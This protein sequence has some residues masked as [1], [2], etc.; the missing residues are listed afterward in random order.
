MREGKFYW[1]QTG[2]W[3]KRVAFPLG[4]VPSST[5]GA[6]GKS[7][8]INDFSIEGVTNAGMQRSRGACLRRCY[9]RLISVHPFGMR[10]SG[11]ELPAALVEG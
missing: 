11:V 5:E 1:V 10:R 9:R 7:T 2:A 6:K 3:G 4:V 8:V